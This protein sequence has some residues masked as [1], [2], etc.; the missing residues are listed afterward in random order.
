MGSG[1]SKTTEVTEAENYSRESLQD[2]STS[3]S[4]INLH[5]ASAS[6]GQARKSR[7]GEK[8]EDRQESRGQARKSRTGETVEDRQESRQ[9]ARKS[10]TGDKADNRQES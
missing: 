9:Q 5:G 10:T 2:S 1:P 6:R 4:V 8:V 3:F 7:T